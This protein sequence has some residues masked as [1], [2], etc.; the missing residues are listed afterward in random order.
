MSPPH[1]YRR[2]GRRHTSL[3]YFRYNDYC[4][5]NR[6]QSLQLTSHTARRRHQVRNPPPVSIRFYFP[7]YSGRANRDCPSQFL[8][9]HYATRHILCRRS[10]P[11]RSFNRSRF[12]HRCRLCPLVPPVL[13]VHPPRHLN[14]NSLW[15]YICGSQPHLLPTTLPRTSRNAPSVL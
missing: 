15:G 7:L 1:V 4:H 8:S 11:L 10:F 5:P 9:G 12:R 6:S 14:Q 2:N 13:G 3:L